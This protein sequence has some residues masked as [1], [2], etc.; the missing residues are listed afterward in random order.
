MPTALITG[1]SAGIGLSYAEQ[2]A[3]TGWH[4]VLVARR[5]DRLR[6]L[7]ERLAGEHH[8]RA[9][10]LAADLANDSGVAAVEARIANGFAINLVVNNAGFAARGTVAELNLAAFEAM[11]R[12][13]VLALVRLS[14]AAMK[15][16]T[17]EAKGAIVNVAS[18]TV[19]MQMPGNAGYGS[20]KNFVMAF[21]RHMHVE[22]QGSGVQIQLLIPGV[23]ATE[24][25]EVAGADLSR[26]P[27]ERVMQADDLVAASLKALEMGEPVC[28][29]SLP[30]VADW[31]GY[32]AAEQ[33]LMPNVSRDRVAERYRA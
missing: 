1:A 14:H 19:F 6:G 32:V 8:I 25:H 26:Y 11:L 20:T 12:V 24:F 27:P 17:A 4:L 5:E 29:P 33:R 3:A 13:N 30:D 10:V 2:L 16:M 15:R 31:D 18:G 7:A 23:I 28:I 22:A 9:E 21:T